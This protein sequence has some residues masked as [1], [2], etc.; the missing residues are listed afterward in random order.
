MDNRRQNLLNQ[1]EAAAA[2]KPFVPE[3][4]LSISFQIMYGLPMELQLRAAIHICER[5]LPIF[6]KKWPDLTWCRQLVGDI[7]AWHRAEGEGTPDVP[8]EADSA[9]SA[10]YFGFIYLLCG[11][12]DKDDPVAFT[13]GVCGTMFEAICA[14]AIN[15][16]LADD[17]I[18][19]RIEQEKDAYHRMKDAYYRNEDGTYRLEEEDGP[20]EPDHFRDLWKP[21]HKRYLNV[22][23]DAVYRREW[24]HIAEWLRAE[25]VW[26]YPEPDDMDAMMRGLKRWEAKE[27][28]P[29][30]PER[31]EPE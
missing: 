7:D 11:Y 2:K 9:E 19:A 8:D 31:K 14:R 25:E 23:Y 22:A 1:L 5:Y 18:A 28:Y 24:R 13:S 10:Y 3:D 27:F 12:H 17:A 6:E 30:G 4:F 29:M 16:Y 26:K 20:P 21:E 15:V